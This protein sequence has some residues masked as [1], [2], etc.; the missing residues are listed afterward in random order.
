MSPRFAV[1][2]SRELFYH[3]SVFQCK[4]AAATRHLLEFLPTLKGR[5]ITM[6]NILV[7]LRVCHFY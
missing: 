7:S 6:K 2:N 3:M 4:R 5:K 1:L